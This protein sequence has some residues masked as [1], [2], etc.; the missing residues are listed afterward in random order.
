M[1]HV[2]HGALAIGLIMTV[3]IVVVA[4]VV[5]MEAARCA[6]CTDIKSCPGDVDHG[7][8]AGSS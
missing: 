6:V 7:C 5:V 4:I 1:P 8:Y 2:G 3:V